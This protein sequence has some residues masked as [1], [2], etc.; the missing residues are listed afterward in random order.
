M[1]ER[2]ESKRRRL[3]ELQI[4]NGIADRDVIPIEDRYHGAGKMTAYL[5]G[6]PK[7]TGAM[8]EDE[9]AAGTVKKSKRKNES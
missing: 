7:Y 2:T 1:S 6:G 3:I 4:R 9:R 8:Y 5:P